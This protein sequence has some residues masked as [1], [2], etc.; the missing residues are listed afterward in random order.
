MSQQHYQL[1]APFD[2]RNAFRHQGQYKLH[3]RGCENASGRGTR[4]RDYGAGRILRPRPYYGAIC[5]C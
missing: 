3:D 5:C 4:H 1:P 2:C